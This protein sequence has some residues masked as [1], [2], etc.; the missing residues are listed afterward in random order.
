M[1]GGGYIFIK[2]VSYFTKNITTVITPF[3]ECQTI[4]SYFKT[5][6]REPSTSEQCLGGVTGMV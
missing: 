5:K 6:C 2:S 3:P 4:L 1:H